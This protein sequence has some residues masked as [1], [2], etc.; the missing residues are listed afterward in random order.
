MRVG[1][2]G[3]TFDPIHIGHL[4]AAEEV[5]E[6]MGLDSVW[7]IPA[8]RPPHKSGTGV[9]AFEHRIEMVRIAISGI[10][11]FRVLGIEEAREGFSYS[12]DTLK[13]LRRTYR[14]VDGFFFI[15]GLDA[16]LEI[17]TWKDPG[18]LTD[19]SDLVVIGRG[20]VGWEEARKVVTREFPR[21]APVPGTDRFDAPGQGS[22]HFLPVTNLDVSA[23]G[24]RARVRGR[25]SIRF[26]VPDAVISYLE[27][28][29]LYQTNAESGS[30][31]LEAGDAFDLPSRIVREI[32]KNKGED[33]VVIDVRGRSDFTDYFV[34]A[35]GRSNRHVR[36][37][38]EKVEEALEGE[39]IRCRGIEGLEK[40]DW[41]L[42]DY[43]DVVV[44]IFYEPLRAF[45]DL[46][47]LWHDPQLG[48]LPK[49]REGH[50]SGEKCEES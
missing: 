24:I 4:R 8:A 3:G 18:H 32:E 48:R 37:I 43:G 5:R 41:V 49:R 10:G 40:A 20:Q 31:P 35:H 26:L 28:K 39:G 17:G 36:G 30:I 50:G 44:H 15:L 11:H 9:T 7:F 6:A 45:Y 47:G 25:R 21:H 29:K 12:V 23:S 46:E 33:V 34:V 2:L 1:I 27:D 14:D 19:H 22:I 42:M 13:E 38:A 16:F